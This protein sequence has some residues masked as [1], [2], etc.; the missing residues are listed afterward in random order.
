MPS[1][2]LIRLGELLTYAPDPHG[3][4]PDG[5]YPIA[6][7][8]GF[9]RG[10]I[11]R[12]AV[13]GREMAATQLFRIRAGQ[14]VYSRLKSFEGAYAIVSPEV[15]GYFVSNE[16]PTF[17][18]HHGLEPGF[19]GW[20]F[21][22]DCVWRQLASDGKGIGARRERLHPTRLLDHA[23]PLPPIEQQRRIIAKLDG[24]ALQLKTMRRTADAARAELNATMK[25]AFRKV[26]A[27]APRVAMMDIA[28]LVRRPIAVDLDG[29]YP[30]LGVRSFGKGTFRKPSLSGIEVGNKRL[31]EIHEGDLLFNIVF[32][33][34]GAVALASA[35][36]HGRVGSHRFLTCVP[37]P[38]RATSKFLLYYFL[39]AEG[40]ERLGAASP[41][42]AGR[43]RT[44]GLKGLESIVVPAPSLDAQLWFD[45]LQQK[46]GAVQAGQVEVAAE[47]D[48]LIPAL[49]HQA[50]D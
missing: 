26:I 38:Q 33:W 20:Y 12:A 29:S 30:E 13:T 45:E 23:I 40:T 47:L 50:F 10:M 9:G 25:A 7:I 3:V 18:L 36:D 37:D 27:G 15:D 39:T 44:L 11:Q 1:F 8:Y 49:M 32:A 5:E 14:F 4:E 41:G 24:A 22:Q 31:F 46:A 48:H 6:G 28:P 35:A 19:L 21:K 43:N 34:E 42:G 16:F 17:D 2:P